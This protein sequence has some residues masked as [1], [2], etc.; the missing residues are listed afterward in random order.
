M[1]W[2]ERKTLLAGWRLLEQ[3]RVSLDRK[4]Y[5]LHTLLGSIASQKGV[6]GAGTE[7]GEREVGGA[8]RVS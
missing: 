3:N 4:S 2:C 7:G 6:A 8:L 1:K 5:L